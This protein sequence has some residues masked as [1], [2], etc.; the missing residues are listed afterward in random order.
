MIMEDSTMM[1][2]YSDLPDDKDSHKEAQMSLFVVYILLHT[3]LETF[4]DV[5]LHG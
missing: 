5:P 2:M 4:S 1:M 3:F